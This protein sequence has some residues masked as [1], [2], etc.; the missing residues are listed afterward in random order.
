[1][2][3]VQQIRSPNREIPLCVQQRQVLRCDPADGGEGEGPMPEETLMV[4][5][6]LV[7]PLRREYRRDFPN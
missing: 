1:V 2:G 7:H 3:R 4:I 6:R 5:H